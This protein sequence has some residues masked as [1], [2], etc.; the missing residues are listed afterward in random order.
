MEP[1]DI[2]N[3]ASAEPVPWD[4]R[5]AYEKWAD[6]QG[7]P[8]VTGFHIPDLTAVELAPW[9]SMGALGAILQIDGT[10]E[11]NGAYI[12]KVPAGESCTWQKR[13]FEELLYVVQ[14]EGLTEV[15]T[16]TGSIT[17]CRWKS[18]SVFA[19][20]LNHEYRHLAV[21]DALFYC[22]NSAPMVMNLFHSDRF[23]FQNP[24][25][26]FD[27]F[28]GAE[29]FFSPDGT[30]WARKDGATIWETN[31]IEDVRNLELPLL[32][33]RGAGGT[34]L[35]F[36]LA[37]GTVVAHTSEFPPGSYKKAHRHGPGAHVVMLSGEGYT[38]LWQDALEDM[39]DITWGENAIIV[40]PSNWYHQH[41]NIGETRARY[42]AMRWGSWKHRLN[43][44]N[45]GVITDRRSGGGQIEYDD[46][47]PRIREIF[48][49]RRVALGR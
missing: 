34:N 33:Q 22:V 4:E 46:E 13:M 23:V 29:D 9:E 24:F 42:L 6:D 47:D 16:P 14:G 26:E 7:V 2:K 38:L 35:C 20:P 11:T 18:G 10:E 32:E 37:D 27:R 31:L 40:P 21:E 36:E 45:E 41:F 12:L 1:F 17:T 43:H 48:E 25:T 5:T 3:V 28:D 30:F 49:E 39:L 44:H 8:I 15:K 19:V